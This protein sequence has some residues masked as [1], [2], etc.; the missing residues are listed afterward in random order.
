MMPSAP[1]RVDSSFGL[2]VP[3]L[4]HFLVGRNR[5]GE[6]VVRERQS[7]LGILFHSRAE[8]LAFAF[9]Q[10]GEGPGA[11]VVVPDILDLSQAVPDCAT[12]SVS[13]KRV[14]R[15]RIAPYWRF[16]P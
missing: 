4:P 16:D 15:H 14:K 12:I 7:R 9:R 5:C 6:W 11:V 8:A 13:S 1:A 2:S 10:R 3:H